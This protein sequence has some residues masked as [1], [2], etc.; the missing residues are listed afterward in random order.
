MM[1]ANIDS[2]SIYSPDWSVTA[3]DYARHRAGYPSS[4]F[5]RLRGLGIGLPKQR[6]VDVGT[7]TG[8]LA[9]GFARAGT[10][11]VGVDIAKDSLGAAEGLAQD[12]GVDVHFVCAPAEATGLEEACFDVFSAGQCWPWFDRPRAAAEARRLLRAGGHILISRFDFQ[13][14]GVTRATAELLRAS[15]PGPLGFDPG[16]RFGVD[17]SY[18]DD[19]EEAGFE[20]IECFSYDEPV[21]YTRDDWRGRIRASNW[22]AA[23]ED[24]ARREVDAALAAMLDSWPESFDIPHRVFAVW[25]IAP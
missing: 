5:E 3:E 9:R 13:P 12:E 19:C 10:E 22:L 16:A 15:I 23:L 11:V 20:Q 25:A 1:T 21:R 2:R 6:L 14:C 4:F 18:L 24:D 17:A 8:T 7:G